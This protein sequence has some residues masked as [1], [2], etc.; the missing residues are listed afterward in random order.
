M[1]NINISRHRTELIPILD[2]LY[3]AAK[4]QK[5]L[6]ASDAASGIMTPDLGDLNSAPFCQ[7]ATPAWEASVLGP[8]IST[9]FGIELEKVGAISLDKYRNS[10]TKRNFLKPKLAHLVCKVISFNNN[11][12]FDEGNQMVYFKNVGEPT[13]LWLDGKNFR[14]TTP[15]FIGLYPDPWE[16]IKGDPDNHLF[17][18][19]KW[20]SVYSSSQEQMERIN[21][22]K[23]NF[24]RSLMVLA[25]RSIQFLG[26]T[27]D[28]VRMA[29]GA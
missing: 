25:T 10:I 7:L 9:L 3:V 18:Y 8:T 29:M 2:G 4:Q 14:L 28:L 15:P 6:L 5:G 16:A 22:A 17:G 27:G 24:G 11:R 13:G 21:V 20:P 23:R 12:F 19:A 26:N 1:A